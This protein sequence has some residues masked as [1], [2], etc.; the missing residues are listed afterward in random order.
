MS[1]LPPHHLWTLQEAEASSPMQEEK[2]RKGVSREERPQG[3]KMDLLWT[4][5]EEAQA[6]ARGVWNIQKDLERSDW[7]CLM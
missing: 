2:E 7:A 5:N 6:R 1:S 4:Q 3:Y